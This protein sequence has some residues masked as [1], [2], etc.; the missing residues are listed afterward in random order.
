VRTSLRLCL[1]V[2]ALALS[3]ASANQNRAPDAPADP[4][5]GGEAPA[6]EPMDESLAMGLWKSSFG[7]VKLERDDS[8]DGHLMGVWLYDRS[9]QE[10]V[11]FFAGP[12]SGNVLTFSWEEP[13]AGGSLRGGG[14]LVFDPRGQSFDGRWWTDDRARGGEWNGWRAP[15]VS[16]P[17]AAPRSVPDASGPAEQAPPQAPEQPDYI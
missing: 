4:G 17:A 10:V 9:G 13:S 12:I 6:P 15:G 2:G 14:Y 1:L 5:D 8:Q 3:L 16:A 11:G 7:A